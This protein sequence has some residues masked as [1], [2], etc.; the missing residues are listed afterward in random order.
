VNGDK[1]WA[2]YNDPI[3]KVKI[4]VT[5]DSFQS[6]ISHVK[7]ECLSKFLTMFSFLFILM[8]FGFGVLFSFKHKFSFGALFS[9]NLCCSFFF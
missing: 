7:L 3:S 1:L 5:Q 9:F 4:I 6:L 2:M 8:C